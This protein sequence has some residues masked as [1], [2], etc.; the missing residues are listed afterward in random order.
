[1]AD[2]SNEETNKNIK[3]LL[4]ESLN[5]EQDPRQLNTSID[6]PE[7]SPEVSK[8]R[9]SKKRQCAN[10]TCSRSKSKNKETK[11]NEKPAKSGCGSCSLGDAFRCEGCPYKGMPAFKEGEEFKF[12]DSLND[13]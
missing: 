3:S 1:M 4:E 13:L 9:S 12:T 5:N 2:N 8:P 6:V 11:T 10:C 7:L